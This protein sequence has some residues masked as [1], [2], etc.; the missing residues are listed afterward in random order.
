MASG[1]A[2]EINNPLAIADGVSTIVKTKIEKGTLKED[3]LLKKLETISENHE[4]IKEVVMRMK[5]FSVDNSTRVL[6]DVY[7]IDVVKE[8]L[9]YF[10]EKLNVNDIK[11]RMENL[12]PNLFF[13]CRREE[14]TQIL[15]SFLTNAI[16]AIKESENLEKKEISFFTGETESS[17]SIS[18]SDTGNTVD[19]LGEIFTPFYTTKDPGKGFG[20]GLSLAQ[21]LANS[22]NGKIDGQRVGDRTI[23]TLTLPK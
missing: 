10:T 19:E 16:D 18:I 14:M 13:H 22:Y 1:I 2:H 7:F 20:L 23:F 12:D 4:R 11:F 9:I 5:D 6:Q 21:Y 8:N 17:I 15:L 3:E